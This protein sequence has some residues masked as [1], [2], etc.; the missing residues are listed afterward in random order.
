MDHVFTGA[1]LRHYR[2]PKAPPPQEELVA[3]T[4]GLSEVVS[5]KIEEL[6]AF[7]VELEQIRAA[8]LAELKKL[9][10][11]DS[12]TRWF[13]AFWI[14]ADFSEYLVVQKWLRYWLQFTELIGHPKCLAQVQ[15]EKNG[16]SDAQLLQ[17]KDF[18]I[19]QLYQGQL[20]QTANRLMGL[21]PFHKE[22]TPSFVIYEDNRYHCFGCGADGDSIDFVM[23]TQECDLPTA[24]KRLL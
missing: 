4:D 3:F 15:F 7:A 9:R 24:V 20:R 16:L 8:R 14:E 22:T 13:L 6:N 1:Q 23:K 2:Y 17:A 21:C 12:F 18:P 5:E 10:G 19:E 11:L